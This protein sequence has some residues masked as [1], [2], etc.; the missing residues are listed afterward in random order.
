MHT[1]LYDLRYGFRQ[2]RKSPGF[3]MAAVL[4]LALGIGANATIF[5][6]LNAVLLNP[7]PGANSR[8]LVSIG[9]RMPGGGQRGLS[10]P[11]FLDYR[12]RNHTLEQLAA[13]SLAPVSL[14]G[15]AQPERLWGML[16]SANYF[17]AVGVKTALGR[18][19]VPE[20][21]ENP[22][23]HPVVVLSHHL[24]LRKFGGDPEIVGRQIQLNRRAFTVVGVTP[25]RFA[26]S[27]LGLRFD[28]WIPLTMREAI[29]GD[30]KALSQ[31]GVR[32]LGA[33]ARLK[34]GVDG[35][36][37]AADLTAISASL[38]R[39]FSHSEIFPRAE[40]EAIWHEGGG[41]VLV[42]VMV[43]LM[44]VTAVVLMIACAN[45]ANLML[46]RAGGRSREIAIRLA[47][48]MSRPRL[49]G[50][51]L[52]ENG[53]L[54]LAGL[55]VALLALPSTMAALQGFTPSS[56]LPVG[57]DVRADG[58]VLLFT[59]GVAAAA[60]LL[61]GL[62]PALS[63]SRPDVASALKDDSGASAGRTKAWLRNS[64]VIAQVSLSLVLL[65]GA[66]LLLKSL[67]RAVSA[68]PGFD[69]RNALVAGVDLEPNGYDAARGRVALRQMTDR[70]SALHGVTA[71][72]T[73]NRV[74]LGLTGTNSSRFEAEGYV[75]AKNEELIAAT[76]VV[77][78]DYF[79]TVNTPV[80]AGREFTPA[81]TP[82][83]QPVAMVNETFARHYL[84]GGAVGRRIQIFG[85]SRMVAG[86]V[87]D[88]KFHALNEK[89]APF[90][91]VP[92]G[93]LFESEANFVIRTAGDPQSYAR[94]VERAI[95][96]VDAALPVFGVR[97]LE[98]AISA[99]YFGQRIGGSFLGFFGGVALVLAAIGL[100]GVLAY[101]V[102][103]RSREV[104]IRMALGAS[105]GDVL[106][107]ILR[108]GARLAGTGLAIGLAI[109]LGVTR[110]MRSLLLDVSPTDVPTILG[111]SLLLA[112]VAL[113]ASF[114]PAHSAS[115]IDPIRSI[116]HQ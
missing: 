113:L 90:V 44:A 38:A 49:V 112:M 50:Q 114:V 75:P 105:R 92:A 107:L 6:W 62:A 51:L 53:L 99:S 109:A 33:Q 10:W 110:L 57:L 74:P 95:H 13:V 8:G 89:P 116:R 20:E 12:Q 86:V 52:V 37:A 32:W 46:V 14:S 91:Y 77:G 9:W 35:R 56:D 103:Q 87:R 81:D 22:G 23:G 59:I 102:S 79:H 41:E 66:G 72:S 100:Y 83:S 25:E 42:P 55:A 48:G 69:P 96:E 82:E 31:R 108:Q 60:M 94:E 18:T 19:F 98:S 78:A 1:L 73:A 85:Q 27:V 7:I 101:T 11:D 67:D 63:A 17:G 43:L 106:S 71:V 111:V 21:D 65:V 68:D 54:A 104:G 97:P 26:G 2:L 40:A 70:I 80:L 115:K 16:V 4:T 30:A 29:Y 15:G 58:G 88:S 47:L 39:E 76:N 36:T 3:T 34:P 24:W 93:Q 84:R 64:L 45:V 28:L 5:S 61:F